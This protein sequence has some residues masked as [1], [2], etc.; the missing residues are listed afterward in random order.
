PEMREDRGGD[1]HRRKHESVGVVPPRARY[2]PGD[3]TA[4]DDS[5]QVRLIV[6]SDERARDDGSGHRRYDDRLARAFGSFREWRRRAS[7]GC[8]AVRDCCPFAAPPYEGDDDG[9]EQKREP[10]RESGREKRER[11]RS[12]PA[13][14]QGDEH[15]GGVSWIQHDRA[16][17]AR[18][19][20][21]VLLVKRDPRR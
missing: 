20:R 2:T 10:D 19:S 11:E 4:D 6:S 12:G 7:R 18:P 16:G 13:G 9:G 3:E 5:D 8:V 17:G 1:E 21:N 15:R 14:A